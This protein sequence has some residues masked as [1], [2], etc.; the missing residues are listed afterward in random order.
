MKGDSND[1]LLE[2]ANTGSY[3]LLKKYRNDAMVLSD[4]YKMSERHWRKTYK[5]LNYPLIV[6][7]TITGVMSSVEV[8]K[9]ALMAISFT[10][11]L[12]TSFST[13]IN[14][15]DKE[16][17]ANQ[18]ATEFSEISSNINQFIVENHKTKDEIKAF[19]Q[20]QLELLE[21]WQ[22]LAPPISYTYLEKAKMNHAPRTRA[23]SPGL[24]N[25]SLPKR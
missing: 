22:S 3:S 13:A 25:R 11:L 18:V 17:K 5:M 2:L 16:A 12:L 7:T 14:P 6:L 1:I 15:K 23:I 8:S 21:V 19:S 9:Y 20:L 4:A 24:A 10:S